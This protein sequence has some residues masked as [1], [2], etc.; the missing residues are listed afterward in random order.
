MSLI[1]PKCSSWPENPHR[2]ERPDGLKTR[3]I[4]LKSL[5]DLKVQYRFTKLVTD[6][7]TP[8]NFENPIGPKS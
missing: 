3:L 1:R 5:I 8:I 6:L 2:S 7:E 4:N